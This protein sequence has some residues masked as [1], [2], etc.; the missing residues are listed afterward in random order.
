M[1]SKLCYSEMSKTWTF[2]ENSNTGFS[3]VTK[4]YNKVKIISNC[5]TQYFYYV[6]KLVSKECKINV[7]LGLWL[8]IFFG[9]A[10]FFEG[11][12]LS[13]PFFKK[14]NIGQY[15]SIRQIN[16]Y[17]LGF[18]FSSLTLSHHL[19]HFFT[20]PLRLSLRNHYCMW[21]FS[22]NDF[23]GLHLSLTGPVPGEG[24]SLSRPP[25]AEPQATLWKYHVYVL[26]NLDLIVTD[27]R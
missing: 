13:Y 19:Q 26:S 25:S 18:T 15:N 16:H 27:F 3:T 4:I 20:C 8:R 17:Y 6:N 14:N 23:R 9:E 24:L 21:F 5:V 10:S 7:L 2:V 22:L 1:I 11:L 12:K